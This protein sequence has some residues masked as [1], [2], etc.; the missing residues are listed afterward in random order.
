VVALE[1]HGKG[2]LAITLRYPYEVRNADDYC[3]FV[4]R[5]A[6]RGRRKLLPQRGIL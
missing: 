5:L 2:L 1:P 4:R 6:A 3:P